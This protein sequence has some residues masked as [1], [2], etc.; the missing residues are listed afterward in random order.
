M[1]EPPV[2][3]SGIQSEW[4]CI[5]LA[6]LIIALEYY[7]FGQVSIWT[8]YIVVIILFFVLFS[9]YNRFSI[10]RRVF[11]H[12]LHFA[13]SKVP[14]Q[15]IINDLQLSFFD[16]MFI[17]EDIKNKNKLPIEIIE[18]SG[19]VVI[20]SV[21]KGIKPISPTK[22]EEIS[23]PP[24]IKEAPKEEL[25]PEMKKKYRCTKCGQEMEEEYKYCPGCGSPLKKID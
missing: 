22:P 13:N 6:I 5:I 1:E 2:K 12:L 16:V 7:T 23:K 15:N 14:I 11:Q 25:K 10:R 8:I 21:E 18:K 19:E 24:S 3:P 20:G 17:L 9:F 4:C